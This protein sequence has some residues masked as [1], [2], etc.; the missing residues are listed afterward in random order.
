M[1]YRSDAA[2]WI[3]NQVGCRIGNLVEGGEEGAGG[4]GGALK[5]GCKG[6]L[7]ISSQRESA[8]LLPSGLKSSKCYV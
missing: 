6:A 1:E 5:Y 2:G 7:G 8:I 3:G 4:A